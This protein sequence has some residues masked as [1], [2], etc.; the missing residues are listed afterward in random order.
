[1]HRC[2]FSTAVTW[3]QSGFPAKKH[4]GVY[5]FGYEGEELEVEAEN[6]QGQSDSC[7]PC[8]LAVFAPGEDS[9]AFHSLMKPRERDPKRKSDMSASVVSFILCY[10]SHRYS[11]SFMLPLSS[12][13]SLLEVLFRDISF[14]AARNPTRRFT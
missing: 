4:S 1:M 3:H 2:K 14:R 13:T 7:M 12:R 9:D 6:I 8:I 11:L 10:L 5:G